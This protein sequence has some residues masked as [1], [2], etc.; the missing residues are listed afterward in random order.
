MGQTVYADL[1][2]MINFSMD[3]LCFF[4]TAKILCAHFPILRAVCG[5]ALGGLYAVLALVVPTAALGRVGALLC[6][7]AVCALIC[8]AVFARRGRMKELFMLTPV[9]I[10][11]SIT[12]GGVMTVLFGLLDR[13][14]LP[15]PEESSGD[16]RSVF[17]FAVC[18]LLG[19][20]GVLVGGRAF[21]R[22]STRKNAELRVELGSRSIRVR[23]LCDSGNLL[24]DPISGAPCVIIEAE[25]LRHI[26]PEE[27]ISAAL[28]GSVPDTRAMGGELGRRIRVIPSRTA[29]GDGMLIAIRPDGVYVDGGKGERRV[30]AMIA[31]SRLGTT[32][33][34]SEALIPPEL[35]TY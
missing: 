31:I 4:L 29:T 20:V 9:F 17:I 8:A 10:A 19:G 11:V 25:R 16:A 30:D 1:Y 13:L 33:D 7:F 22:R 6:D 15:L 5:S 23:A 18:A 14:S 3:F 26:L 2:F 12:L 35:L 28:F 24:R 21:G 27:L 32:A 34:G